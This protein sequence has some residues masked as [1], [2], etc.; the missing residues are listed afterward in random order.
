MEADITI[1]DAMQAVYDCFGLPEIDRE[2]GEFTAQEYADQFGIPY[3]TAV[4][5][6]KRAVQHGILQ[7]RAVTHNG[8]RCNAYRRVV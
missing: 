3:N 7:V 1:E 8:K 6:L 4:G 2:A 5:Q